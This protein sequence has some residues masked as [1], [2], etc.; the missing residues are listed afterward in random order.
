MAEERLA[1]R[2]GYRAVRFPELGLPRADQGK[3]GHTAADVAKAYADDA[4][5]GAILAGKFVKHQRDCEG[6][7]AKHKRGTY[8]ALG[9]AG[10]FKVL[11]PA[12]TQKRGRQEM[13]E[14]FWTRSQQ[15]SI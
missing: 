8:A 6:M 3:Q 15:P 4:L 10:W 5:S 7:V 11:N 14:G 1:L 2:P 9:P 13:F 12:Y